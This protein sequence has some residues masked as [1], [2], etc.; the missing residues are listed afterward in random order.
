MVKYA[1]VVVGADVGLLVRVIVDVGIRVI[2]DANDADGIGWELR[3]PVPRGR[4][5]QPLSQLDVR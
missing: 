5:G 2:N 4:V 1:G 3:I